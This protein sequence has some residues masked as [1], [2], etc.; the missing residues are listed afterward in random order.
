MEFPRDAFIHDVRKRTNTEVTQF[1]RLFTI[2]KARVMTKKIQKAFSGTSSKVAEQV[3]R[4]Y[5]QCD[6][7]RKKN[8]GSLVH[9]IVSM[10]LALTLRAL[11]LG[12][13]RKNYT[14]FFF[15][16][17]CIQTLNMLLKEK[18]KKKSKIKRR[19]PRALASHYIYI[20]RL[21]SV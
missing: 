2:T 14:I 19:Q 13:V 12:G 6:E 5:T 9:V 20:C 15:Y 3:P 21:T 4:R 11:L 16:F 18:E 7:H 17:L 10:E 8:D 1:A